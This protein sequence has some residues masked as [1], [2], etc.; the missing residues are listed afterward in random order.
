MN[1]FESF[2]SC[3][4]PSFAES[5][6]VPTQKKLAPCINPFQEKQVV[7]LISAMLFSIGAVC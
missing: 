4:R 3:N 6:K 7:L 2:R 1:G 5:W